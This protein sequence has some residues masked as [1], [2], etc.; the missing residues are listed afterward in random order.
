MVTSTTI[1]NTFRS[2]GFEKPN[3]IDRLDVVQISS[4]INDDTSA[5]DKSIGELDRLFKLLCIGG[6]LMSANEYVVRS[7]EILKLYFKSC[8]F[9]ISEF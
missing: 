9:T 8:L 1:K 4:I 7:P 3:F 2:A 6:K 5:A